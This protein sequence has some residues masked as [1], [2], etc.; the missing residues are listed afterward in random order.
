MQMRGPWLGQVRLAG[1]RL[2][3]SVVMTED[4]LAQ[5][6]NAQ[7]AVLLFWQD[8]CPPCM[9][10]KPVFDDVATG[11]PSNVFMGTANLVDMP[12]ADAKYQIVST[13]TTIFLASGQEINRIEGPMAKRD[14]QNMI[15][16][17]FVGVPTAT[18]PAAPMEPPPPAPTDN[19][20]AP[21]TPVS[22][23]PP[24]GPQG[25]TPK[26]KVTAAPGALS[27]APS[28][29]TP[30]VLILGGVSLAAIAGAI[31]LLSGGSK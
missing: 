12:Q 14:L 9:Q 31:V 20:P 5:A 21:S 16:A 17:A 30:T 18:G 28:F 24:A 27:A 6:E 8:G 1:F 10:Y 26:P 15:S 19:G 3:D 4:T 13:P 2:G 23:T 11:E 7:F 29:L 25:P 22:Q